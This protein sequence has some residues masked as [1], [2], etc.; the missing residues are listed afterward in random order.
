MEK[1][2][3]PSSAASLDLDLD[4]DLDLA[5]SDHPNR[6]SQHPPRPTRFH[7]K[8]TKLKPKPKPEPEPESDALPLL[9]KQ[10]KE[11][12]S[13]LHLNTA[14]PSH[15]VTVSKGVVSI[16]ESGMDIDDNR[17]GGD[18]EDG[19]VR[20]IDVF[21]TP[22]PLD[23]NAQL[24][25]MQY[26]LRPCWR[27]YE[28]K[29]SCIEV[30]VKPKQSKLE[31]DLELNVD[32][33]NYDREVAEPFRIRKQTLSS[34]KAPIITGYAVGILMGDKLHLNPVHAVVQLRPSREYLRAGKV[35]KKN[36]VT[37]SVEVTANSNLIT[38]EEP[39]M[40]SRAQGKHV[41]GAANEKN[42]NEEEPWVSLEYHDIGS[43][44]S[45]KYRQKM[46]AEESC[47]IQFLMTLYDYTNSLCPGTSGDKSHIKGPPRRFLLSLPLEERFKR[48]LSEGP[49][50][51]RFRALMHLAPANSEDD[52][53]KVVQQYADL[54]Q[55]LWVS[56]SSLLYEGFEALARDYILLLFSK[57]RFIRHDELKGLKV[58]NQILKRILL[59]LAVERSAFRD[60][61]FKEPED[62]L[63]IKCHPDIVEEQ[64][65]AWSAR[66]KHITDA[67]HG[68]G[69][70]LLAVSKN[71]SK[72]S[73]SNRISASGN[74]DEGTKG[75]DGV[76]GSRKVTMSEETREALPKA[77]VELFRIHK[78][79]SLQLICQGLRD[80]AVSKSTHPKADPRMAIAAAQGAKALPELQS[81]LSQ[82]AINIH[83]AYVLKS[84]G[85]A[86]VDPFRNVVINLFCAMQP[87]AKLKKAEIVEAARIAL[88]REIPNAEYNQVLNELC[89]SVKGG[90]WM[91]KS[92]DGKPK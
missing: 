54:V 81:I 57:N 47:H 36:N 22:S 73:T 66:L 51:H 58:H 26:P 78:V 80:M 33:E 55:G 30:R 13:L 69:R 19:V 42:T 77:L 86:S 88:K 34:S 17:G 89:V 31:V 50:V 65:Q 27:P 10:Q 2:K 53:L 52:V 59:P 90:A 41:S 3:E 49:Q 8:S 1:W 60:W 24:Y 45:S 11:G 85:N 64:K 14:Q 38:K 91:L 46:A 44:F 68:V 62:G 82:V 76:S 23:N 16:Q 75:V 63:F 87:N 92:G 83:G 18:D 70:S 28:L 79:C 37:G 29:E 35:Q 25:V 39:A 56:K 67:M 6:S 48:W 72:P 4:L 43:S 20:E 5:A 7:P 21:F 12:S 32:G 9:K 61:K 15:A 40:T 71:S 84:L 74:A